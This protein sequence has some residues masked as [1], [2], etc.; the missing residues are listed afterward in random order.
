M[1]T[2]RNIIQVTGASADLYATNDIDG[3]ELIEH[4]TQQP[5]AD[6][7]CVQ[8][9]ATT[10]ALTELQQRGGLTVEIVYTADEMAEHFAT[11][12]KDLDADRDPDDPSLVS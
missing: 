2:E 10:D 5:A 4:G 11:I 12:E 7:Y 3:L 6:Q 8:G 9:T 1:A